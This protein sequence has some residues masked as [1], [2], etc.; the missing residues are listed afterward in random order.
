MLDGESFLGAFAAEPVDVL[1]VLDFEMSRG[2]LRGWYRDTGLTNTDRLNL[3]PLRGQGA[4]FDPRS[5]RLRAFWAAELAGTSVL[6]LDPLS[7]VLVSLGIDE[8]DNS[9]VGA[10]LA[11]LD[12]LAQEVGGAELLVTHHYGRAN[13]RSRGA[14]VLMGWADSLW[15]L[16]RKGQ[17]EDDDGGPEALFRPVSPRTFAANG[18]DVSDPVRELAYDPITRRLSLSGRET[19]R[20]EAEQ[21]VVLSVLA[22]ASVPLTTRDLRRIFAHEAKEVGC[23]LRQGRLRAGR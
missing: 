23:P 11:A 20:N 12:A 14:S 6:R 3:V 2:Q 9:Q 7:P 5:D 17:R 13:G 16:S 15:D 19:E 22:G 18:R 4:T 21:E 8:N 10:F 1:T